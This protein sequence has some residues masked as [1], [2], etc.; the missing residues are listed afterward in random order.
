MAIHVPG[1]RSRKGGV[2]SGK[3]S[4]VAVLQLTAMVDMFT[5]MVVFL[6][7]NYATTNQVLPISDKVDLPAAMEVKDLKPSNVVV[8]SDEGVS[9][10]SKIV[11]TF[12]EVKTQ[13]DWL[14]KNLETAVKDVIQEGQDKKNSLGT[15][16][17]DAVNEAKTGP[18]EEEE[19]DDFLKITIQADKGVDFLS[20]KKIMYTVTEAGVQEI[21]FAVLKKPGEES[22][23]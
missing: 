9:F 7:Q 20:V 17:R 16:I 12:D 1:Y 14:L 4:A 5:V 15:K 3:R 23:N 18:Q 22:V 13:E 11:A 6:L 19:V 8:I 2:K 10:N 21:N